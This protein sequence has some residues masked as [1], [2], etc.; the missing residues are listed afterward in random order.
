MPGGDIESVLDAGWGCP[1]KNWTKIPRHGITPSSTSDSKVRLLPSPLATKRI[2]ECLLPT[3]FPQVG[4]I[5]S[6][7]EDSESEQELIA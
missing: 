2:F 6:E 5:L 7:E 3:P 1:C 4:D